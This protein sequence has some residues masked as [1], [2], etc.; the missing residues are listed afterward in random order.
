MCLCVSAGKCRADGRVRRAFTLIE[1]LVV[2]FIIGILIALL[3][4]GVQSAREAARRAQCANNLKQLG[5]ALHNYAAAV[6]SFPHSVN[7]RKAYSIHA[8][9][10]PQLDQQALYNGFNFAFLPE[11]DLGNPNRTVVETRIAVLVCPSDASLAVGRM[12]NSYPANFGYGHQRYG[13]N[14]TFVRSPHAPTRVADIKDET[15]QTA[16]FCEWVL[17]PSDGLSRDPIRMIFATP[18]RLIDPK[19]LDEFIASCQ[20]LSVSRANPCPIIKGWNWA[21]AGHGGTLYNHTLGINARSCSN[22]G[23]MPNGAYSAG[24]HHGSLAQVLF[25]DGHVRPI[26]EGIALNVWRAL[27][28]REGG[29]V[30]PADF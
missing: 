11:E 16:A 19:E 24:S 27:A 9:L 6:G 17:G 3:L 5:L 1:L 28:T 22:G 14:G 25:V 26:R 30:L 21:L 2:I 29:E 23:N 12:W 13:E 20:G 15:S 7:A 8:M 18:K 10:L 4:S